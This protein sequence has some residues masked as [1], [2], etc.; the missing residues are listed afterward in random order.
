MALNLTNTLQDHTDANFKLVGKGYSTE[1]WE[2]CRTL[3][4]P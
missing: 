3:Q 4:E 2:D 1:T